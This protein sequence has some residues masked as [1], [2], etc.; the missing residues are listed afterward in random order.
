MIWLDVGGVCFRNVVLSW[1]L[2]H[3]LG[4]EFSVVGRGRLSVPRVGRFTGKV[5]LG[6]TGGFVG[7]GGEFCGFLA[8]RLAD[9]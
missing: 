4:C 3:V 1:Y 9:D 2:V 7:A 6:C 8:A 5:G